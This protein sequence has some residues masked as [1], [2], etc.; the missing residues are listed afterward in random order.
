MVKKLIPVA[1]FA[2]I[3][4]QNFIF[5]GENT[6]P[7]SFNDKLTDKE[8]REIISIVDNFGDYIDKVEE[9]SGDIAFFING[10]WIYYRGGKM[11]AEKNLK[12]ADRYDSIFYRYKK[13]I[14]TELLPYT[15][16]KALISNDFLNQLFGN[17]EAKI[18]K[19]CR[20]LTFLRRKTFVNKI[21]YK[22]LQKI[23][24][25]LFETAKTNKTVRD[26]IDNIKIA[27]SFQRKKVI[28]ASNYS[29]HTYGMAIDLEPKS[30]DNKQVYWKW[31]RVFNKQ[32]YKIPFSERCNPPQ[33]VI[34]IFEKNGF[35]WGGKWLH[36]DTIHFEYRPVILELND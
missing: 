1:L 22:P 7:T 24:E 15:D 14:Q 10:E 13:G 36:F 28:Y 12:N 20:N 31:S 26:Y 16:Y 19:N 4:G 8:V 35:I 23:Q 34:D 6:S 17:T 30:F 18:R 32:W 21:C 33:E 11:I 27:Y 3:L 25:E 5:A 29:Y 9:R 2:F